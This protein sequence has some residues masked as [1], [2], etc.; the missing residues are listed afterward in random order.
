GDRLEQGWLVHSRKNN[1]AAQRAGL[2]I[3]PWSWNDHYTY[4]TLCALHYRKSCTGEVLM[5]IFV[6]HI[7]GIYCNIKLVGFEVL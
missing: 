5:L 1:T 3:A 7:L 2:A 4:P 6:L